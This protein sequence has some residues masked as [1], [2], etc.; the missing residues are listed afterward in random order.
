MKAQINTQEERLQRIKIDYIKP[1]DGDVTM[2]KDK[3]PLEELGG[4]LTRSR[5]RKAK[6]ALQQVLSILFEYKPKF[7]REKTK[8]VNCIVA[9]MEGD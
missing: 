3:D 9:Q 4:P 5:A 1:S 2:S 7:E 8:V 6:E